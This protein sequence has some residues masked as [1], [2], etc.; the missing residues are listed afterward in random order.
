MPR[1]GPA[2]RRELAP[3]PIYR[4]VLVTQVVNKV[5]VRGKR[6]LAERIVYEALD[7]IAEK[8]GA[9][10]IATLK[11]AVDNVKP[12][13][14]VK[15]RRVGGATYQ[16]PVEVRPRRA[17]TL[18]IRWIVSS[19]ASAASARWP[20]RLANELLD[21]SNG[22]GASV[23]RRGGHAQDGRVQQGVR[24]LPLVAGRLITRHPAGCGPRPLPGSTGAG[25]R[26][27]PSLGMTQPP[28]LLRTRSFWPDSAGTRPDDRW[29]DKAA[30]DRHRRR[31]P[32]QRVLSMAPQRHPLEKTRNIGIMAHIDAGKTTTTERILYYTG[33]NYKIGEVHEGAATM[34]WMVQEQER[35][36]TITSAATT[37]FWQRP[38]HQHHRHARPR[39]LHRRGRAVAARPRRRGRGVRRRGRRRAADRDRLAAGQQV[40][41]PPHLLHQQDGPPRRRLLRRA[42]LHRGPPRGHDRRRAAAHRRRGPLPG[43]GRPR[44][45]ERHRLGPGRR[46]RRQLRRRRHPRGPRRAGRRSGATSSSTCCRSSTSRSP[47]SSS[48]EEEITAEDLRGALRKG[49][50]TN[51]LVPV[52]NGTAFKNKGV[53]P[54]LDAVVA[55][56]PSPLD[57]PPVQGMNLK[58]TETVER[59]PSDDEPLRRPGV[60]DHDRPARRQAHLLPGLLRPARQGRPAPQHPHRQQG[61]DRSP[62]RDA[63]QQPAR[64]S[65]PPA[66][67]T[68]SPA[69]A[70]RT[71]T[72]DTL[73]DAGHPDRARG[74]RVFP[75]PVIHVAVEP[76]TK[77]D[78]DKM[79]KALA[80]LSEED[81]TFQ[82]R[83]DHE[84][85]QTVI[86]GMGELH[87]EVL[88]DRMLREFKVDA[89]VGKPQV[90]YRETITR[91]VQKVEYRHVKQTGGSGPVRRRRHRPRAAPVPAVATSSSTRSPAGASPR[92]T[93]PPSTRASRRR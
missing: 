21:A 69:S 70:S 74:A 67:A 30:A 85:G 87:L 73:C 22:I 59:K 36:I 29:N 71:T 53:Q 93:S 4:S 91:A 38:P 46:P 75:E 65:R 23:K 15:S 33:R 61:A 41:R 8:T 86:S 35:G 83:T 47:T 49:T 28:R 3:D 18:A 26:P 66:P 50:I 42:A 9:E 7:V 37:C 68:S 55:Y 78:Q 17:T 24:P 72:G 80:A 58:G 63:R 39:R 14:E 45:D 32:T 76:K 27:L 40:R 34:D 52:L 57:L 13:L 12:Q 62:A 82:V 2:P 84:T 51:E 77:A 10:P 6:S 44:R 92:S 19:R 20:Q 89:T 11:R 54:L 88:V 31:S 43:R 1:K 48:C 5:L 64:T 56:L 79:S 16:V 60:Q 90:A 81:P 25:S